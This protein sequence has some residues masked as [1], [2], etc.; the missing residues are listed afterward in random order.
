MSGLR[1]QPWR[2][3]EMLQRSGALGQ[4]PR[5]R[6]TS[7]R[8]ASRAISSSSSRSTDSTNGSSST[9]SSAAKPAAPARSTAAPNPGSG[10]RAAAPPNRATTDNISKSG[11]ED[12]PL[13]IES[14]LEDKIDWTR[15][16][17]GLSAEPFSKEIAAILLAETD[18]MEVEV[19]PDGILYLPEIKYRRILN[20]A[21]GPGGWGLAPR[22][23]SI[24]TPKTVTREYA[25]VCHGRLVSVAR[26]EQDYFS[27]DGI[28]T[29]TE[30]CRSN[31]LMRCCKDLGIASELWD[32]R[33]IRNFKAKYTRE[34]FVEHVVNKRKSKIWVRKDDVVSYP[35]KESG[36]K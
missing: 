30:G 34:V 28:P 23:E 10:S 22:G 8:A 32:P 13:E 7:Y 3:V 16:F 25:L 17:H 15:S 1:C 26:G 14:A 12:K 19:K 11:L 31:A 29:A 35:W 21:F 36:S 2:A 5:A 27:P 18:P 6:I 9:T 33:W 20:R 24:V 4:A